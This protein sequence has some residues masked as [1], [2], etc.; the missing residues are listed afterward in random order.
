MRF[1]P[2]WASAATSAAV[3][4]F[5]A[6]LADLVERDGLASAPPGALRVGLRG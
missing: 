6:D 3:A 5:A 1:A 2:A 4:R